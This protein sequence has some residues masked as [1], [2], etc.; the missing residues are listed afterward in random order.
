MPEMRK[1]KLG[2]KILMGFGLLILIA[3]GLGSVAALS[4]QRVQGQS[5]TLA[6]EY[7][8]AVQAANALERGFH[9]L[10]YAIRGFGLTGA[11]GYL[12]DG[13]RSLEQVREA[14]AQTQALV[15]RSPHLAGLQGVVAEMEAQASA[16]AGALEETV[17]MTAALAAD[18]DRLAAASTRYMENCAAFLEVQTQ[19]MNAEIEEGLEPRN[20]RKRLFKIAAVS[21]T[22]V[23]GDAVQLATA[24]AQALRQPGR[25]EGAMA[26]FPEIDG[27]LNLLQGLTH[28]PENLE[29]IAAIREAAEAYRAG[30]D[31]LLV[32]GRRLTELD[33][34][35][36]AL[37]GVVLARAREA[38]QLGIEETLGVA[39]ATATRLSQASRV[40]LG[41]L[42]LTL[43]LGALAAVL[44]T[45]SITRPIREIIGGLTQG[46]DQVAAAAG[47]VSGAS[48]QLAEGA[49]AQ[50]SAIEQTSASLE[51]MTAV[52]RRN[53][54]NAAQADALM[55]TA[56]EVV[57]N[58]DGSMQRLTASMADITRA[59]E[60]TGK[61]I[62]TIDE[63][64]FQTN[65]LALNAAVE[66][67]RA[68]EAGAG[69]AVVADEVRNLA[70]RAAEAARGTAGLIDGTREKLREGSA[71][72]EAT[73]R[74]FDE[75]TRA[76]AEAGR[77]VG[78]ITSASE[79]QAQG[80]AQVSTAV[81][82]VDQVTQRNAA[83]AEESASAAQEMNAQAEEMKASVRDLAHLV[84]GDRAEAHAPAAPRGPGA[85]AAAE[86]TEGLSEA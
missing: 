55:K 9:E 5:A 38:A 67:A 69:F 43:A 76:T 82:E 31:S 15:A 3:A 74:A 73:N 34:R 22:I 75:I 51:E 83:S 47:Q 41:G 1:L 62:K 52:T 37:G 26:L 23:L 81:A 42:G 25:I 65:L 49:G 84:D 36:I 85:P 59:G 4:M 17:A 13:R 40:V 61:I 70:L 39:R 86:L 14:I 28:Q 45:R 30:M 77:L 78:D 12:T 8:P 7:V 44:I 80:I 10:M 32:N 66:A 68:G 48:Q 79:E 20:L 6:A 56:G 21:K 16:Y 64:A 60:E 58:A 50:A 11:A 54:A 46:A 2:Y 33:Q 27:Q 29:H 63:I 19:R 53:A 57:A 35:R 24:Q 71:L 72:V 18:R